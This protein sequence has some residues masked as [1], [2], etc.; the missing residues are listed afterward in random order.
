MFRTLTRTRVSAALGGASAPP[1]PGE[2]EADLDRVPR[3]IVEIPYA[4]PTLDDAT[5]CLLRQFLR[6][7]P[8][9]VGEAERTDEPTVDRVTELCDVIHVAVRRRVIVVAGAN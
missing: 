1:R 4:V 6:E 9:A 5:Q 3:W 2:I 7:V 8:V